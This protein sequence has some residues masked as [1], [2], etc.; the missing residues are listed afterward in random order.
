MI[1]ASTLTLAVFVLL[2]GTGSGVVDVTVTVF[3]IGSGVVY[4]AGTE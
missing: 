4:P 2:P 3:T 1:G